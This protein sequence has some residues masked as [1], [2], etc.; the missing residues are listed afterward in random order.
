MWFG[1]NFLSPLFLRKL[2]IINYVYFLSFLLKDSFE[3]IF[4]FFFFVQNDFSRIFR[5]IN[6]KIIKNSFLT[7]FDQTT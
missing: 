3:K 6:I 5:Q 2:K 4:S 7:P 1:M